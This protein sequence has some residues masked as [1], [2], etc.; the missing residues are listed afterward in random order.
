MSLVG[1]PVHQEVQQEDFSYSVSL[2]E[3]ECLPTP[4][5]LLHTSLIPL[6]LILTVLLIMIMMVAKVA[7]L[8]LLVCERFFPN[9][10]EARVEYLHAKILRKRM[11]K[12][13]PAAASLS[14]KVGFGA[15][16]GVC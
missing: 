1:I 16:G 11:K 14:S 4:Q 15:G 2:F 6:A 13:P 12:R 8:R 3:N 5:L 7:Q 9:A 10:A